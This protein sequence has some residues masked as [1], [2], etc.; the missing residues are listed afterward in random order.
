MEMM[1]QEEL[2]LCLHVTQHPADPT[3]RR[4]APREILFALASHLEGAS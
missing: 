3:S 4:M 1:V 2:G